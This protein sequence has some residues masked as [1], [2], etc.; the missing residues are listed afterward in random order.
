MRILSFWDFLN[1]CC[2]H[3]CVSWSL[4]LQSIFHCPSLTLRS[5]TSHYMRVMGRTGNPG[6]NAVEKGFA[7]QISQL[8]YWQDSF[9]RLLAWMHWLALLKEQ[10]L[11][12]SLTSGLVLNTLWTVSDSSQ[13]L[14]HGRLITN[15][16]WVKE[17]TYGLYR[18]ETAKSFILA[19]QLNWIHLEEESR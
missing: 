13:C 17:L 2:Y 7:I 6:G 5:H 19:L 3:F 18:R 1:P 14:T 9:E 8:S 12:D 15:L 4:F 16:C 11:D 10:L